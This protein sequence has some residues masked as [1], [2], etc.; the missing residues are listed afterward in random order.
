MRGRALSSRCLVAGAAAVAVNI[1]RRCS[2][3][4]SASTSQ[5]PEQSSS[6]SSGRSGSSSSSSDV[7]AGWSA[8]LPHVPYGFPNSHPSLF[9]AERSGGMQR[10]WLQDLPGRIGSR[11]DGAI[12][13]EHHLPS[14]ADLWR[15]PPYEAL[16]EIALHTPYHDALKLVMEHDYRFLFSDLLCH[17]EAPMP[18]VLYEDFMKCLTFASLQ[19]PPE[20]QFALPDAVLR[21]LLCLAAYHCTLDRFYYTSASQLFRKA[22]QEQR[23]SPAA[24]SAWVYVCTAAGK[25][26]E[27]LAHAAYMDAHGLPFDADVFARMLHPSLTPAQQHLRHAQQTSRGVV[28]QRRLCQD[29]SLHHSTTAVA[30]H[31]MFV[32]CILT[33]QH[34]YKW[35]VL[36]SAAEMLLQLQRRH[37]TSVL[38]SRPHAA[39]AAAAAAAAATPSEVIASRTMQL[40]L[41]LFVGEKGIR[42]GPRTTKEMVSVMLTCEEV[43]STVADVVFVLLRI[44]RNER[45]AALA[46]LP[47]TS[48]TAKEQETLMEA[49]R[50]R[51]HRDETYSVAAPLLRELLAADSSADRCPDEAV[52]SESGVVRAVAALQRLASGAASIS[53]TD[54]LDGGVE[55]GGHASTSLATL[56]TDGAMLPLATSSPAE[57]ARDLL[58]AVVSLDS[59]STAATGTARRAGAASAAV[60]R[61]RDT[62]EKER[63]A[64]HTSLQAMGASASLSQ[65]SMTQLRR[66]ADEA[67]WRRQAPVAWISP[68]FV[69]E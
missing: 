15:S 28:L 4:S 42:W 9:A 23:L 26:D 58:A 7:A 63:G 64:L 33:L 45:T 52:G 8:A 14:K 55:C 59:E 69:P 37:S 60:Q 16:R 29:M 67:R 49:V 51:S 1:V 65:W 31:A 21:D 17:A 22:E 19:R 10:H 66:E 50:R 13:V 46:A 56:H 11:V 57:V 61:A 32:Y 18:H 38:A 47:K 34:T 2:T 30:V 44:R 54:A 5:Q 48:F 35:E 12:R 36:R 24:H 20:E 68:R 6:S 53:S 39:G 41:S 62:E 40:A 27:A 25:A 43:G 3:T